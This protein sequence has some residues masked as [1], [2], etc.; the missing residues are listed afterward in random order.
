MARSDTQMRV[1]F[2]VGAFPVTTETFIINQVAD[3]IDAGVCVEVFA[4]RPGMRHGISARY[5]QYG[6]Q[7][8]TRYLHLPQPYWRMLALSVP[9]LVRVLCFN[10]MLLWSLLIRARPDPELYPSRLLFLLAP[11]V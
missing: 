3:L 7:K 10:P 1:A 4:L 11:F 9:R 2:I 8:I 6:M 5:Q